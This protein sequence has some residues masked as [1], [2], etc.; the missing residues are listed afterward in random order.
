VR[1]TTG[2]SLTM[3]RRL[4]TCCLLAGAAAITAFPVAVDASLSDAAVE[5]LTRDCLAR[6][7]GNLV[8]ECEVITDVSSLLSANVAVCLKSA[9]AYDVDPQVAQKLCA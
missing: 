7:G 9:A 8:R 5:V 1:S 2:R 4:A 6:F 3:R